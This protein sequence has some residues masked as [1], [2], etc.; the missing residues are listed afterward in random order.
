MALSPAD[1]YSYSRATGAP[2]PE[3]PEERARMAPEVLEYRR[4]QLKA[5]RQEQQQ[6]PDPLSVGLGIG[7]ALAGGVGGA[8]GLNKLLR[9]RGRAANE[10]NKL[11]NLSQQRAYGEEIGSTVTGLKSERKEKDFSEWQARQSSEPQ[12]SKQP[13]AVTEELTR[14]VPNIAPEQEVTV[15]GSLETD[16]DV[17]QELLDEYV[18]NVGLET[19]RQQKIQRDIATQKEGMAMRV[20][21]ELRQEAKQEAVQPKGFNPR[22]YIEDTGAVAPAEDLTSKQQQELPEVIDQ[23]INAVESG[24]DQFTGRQLLDL[25]RDTDTTANRLPVNDQINTQEVAAQEFL[26]KEINASPQINLDK[27]YTY[28]DLKEE[29]LPDFEIDARMQAYATTGDK[30]LL[31][32]NIN[33]KTLGHSEFLKVLGVRNASINNKMQLLDGKLVNPEGDVRMSAFAQQQPSIGEKTTDTESRPYE[34]VSQG[35]TGLAGGVSTAP[36][37]YKLNEQYEKAIQN[38]RGEWDRN[39]RENI[40]RMASGQ[41][42]YSDIVIPARAE[43]LVDADDLDI[44]VRIETDSEGKV[45]SR[46]LYRDIL[47]PEIVQQIET[48]DKVK[49]DVPFMVNKGRAYLDYRRNPTLTNRATAKDYQR[50]GRAL[51]QKYQSIV[52][53]YEG[54]KYIPEIQEGRFFESGET[55]VTPQRGKGSQR[56][57]LVGGIVEEL[58]SE[59]L[60]PLKYQ[61]VAKEGRVQTQTMGYT[62]GSALMPIDTLDDL[63]QLGPLL[64]TQGNVITVSPAQQRQFVMTQPMSVRRVTPVLQTDEQGNQR[65]RMVQRVARKTGKPFSA[66]LVQL[67]DVIVN[68]P[69]QVLNAKTGE[70]ISG[71][72]QISRSNLNQL[73]DQFEGQIRSTGGT[74]NYQQ[75]ASDLDDYLVNTQNIKLPVLSSN[76]A[77]NFIENLRGRPSSRATT[78]MYATTGDLGDIYPIAADQIEDFIARN[79]LPALGVR[80]AGQTRF[81]STTLSRQM[82]GAP[83]LNI[84]EAPKGTLTG[85]AAEDEDLLQQLRDVRG[86]ILDDSELGYTGYRS[87]ELGSSR[88][89]GLLQRKLESAK[90]GISA[91]MQQMRSQAEAIKG[92]NWKKQFP[93]LFPPQEEAL[94]T[95][96]IETAMSQLLAQA[97]RRSGKRR[98]R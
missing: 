50:T 75:L 10:G 8:Y 68:A 64:D 83:T 33:S 71:A 52:A 18:R 93:N 65:Q 20:I 45:L 16:R 46:T 39:V 15:P 87:V 94:P 51:V 43:R 54:S 27:I 28:Q 78:T 70:E 92:E 80:K 90:S 40:N 48:G 62:S 53:P 47:D 22:K 89:P 57:K 96:N 97:G 42:D 55:G 81:A 41:G 98:N 49:L 88:S 35:M 11:S 86:S 95:G 4:N 26:N 9:G 72:A 74:V 34:P 17:A 23:K 61:F 14:Q 1:F 44:P 21:D 37:S 29:G 24:E 84:Q 82:V 60:V 66:P 12:P 19:K 59:T 56:G 63:N 69:L 73:L 91:E 31:N 77:F 38:F 2:I 3:D 13:I 5:P 85:I 6:G 36:A 32:P 25:Q 30:A 67:E 58:L 79:N 76:T 7:I